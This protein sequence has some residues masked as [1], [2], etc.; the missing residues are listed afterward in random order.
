[1]RLRVRR[2]PGRVPGRVDPWR[3][4]GPF[5]ALA[6][7]A[8]STA[9]FSLVA[10]KS[11]TIADYLRRSS[12]AGRELRVGVLA[13]QPLLSTPVKDP[14]T[15]DPDA[16]KQFTGFDAS[17][18]TFLARS[19]GVSAEFVPLESTERLD[20]LTSGRV[21]V[22]LGGLVITAERQR[23]V[24]FAGP[25]LIGETV[26]A[27]RTGWPPGSE[28]GRL[29]VVPGSAAAADAARSGHPLLLAPDLR[30]C[31]A[32]VSADR[33]DAVVGD[34]ILLRG[35]VWAAGRGW[36]VVPFPGMATIAYGIG[37]AR[38]DPALKALV[39]SFLVASLRKKKS[40]AWEKA[41]DATLRKAGFAG[42]QPYAPGRLLRDGSDG[43]DGTGGIVGLPA[44][45][46]PV[47]AGRSR[48]G[49][50]LAHRRRRR[51]SGRT[52]TRRPARVGGT[53]AGEPGPGGAAPGVWSLLVGVP[54]AV[55]ALYLWIQSGGDRQFTLM[56]AQS[57]NPINFLA[58]VSL[59]V[60]WV[61]PALPA[62]VFIIGAVVLGAAVDGADRRRLRDRYAVAR[63]TDRAPGWAVWGSIL[64]A[65]AS[66]PLVFVPA[67]ALA[68]RVVGRRG[69]AG[70]VG[71]RRPGRGWVA[72]GLL[73]YA[74]VVGA[75]VGA[76]LA[77]G[78]QALALI[79]GWPAVLLLTR[80]TGPL[81]P[82][83][84]AAFVRAAALLAVLLTLGVLYA[85]VSTPILPSTAIQVAVPTAA[86]PTPAPSGSPAPNDPDT[87]PPTRQLRGY[88][89]STDDE[90]TTVLSDRGGVEIVA[91]D[92]IR[93]RVSCPSL[94]DLPGDSAELFGLPLRESLL[95]ALARRQRPTTVQDPRCLLRPDG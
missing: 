53:P 93:S 41:M 32:A 46:S 29:C 75:A 91:N 74:A 61:F 82:G 28:P 44:A 47:V 77:E 36:K 11:P 9:A 24:E 16:Q 26:M 62:L 39:D 45:V 90:A 86:P 6:L 69:A 21:D 81:R 83:Q 25:Y 57:I 80:A 40:G 51:T 84:V 54:V 68:L 14:G 12:I 2:L 50:T 94:V 33:A 34:E 71:G 5:L 73:L 85:V 37:V 15:T 87:D 23:V 20:A 59:S 79:A 92:V 38:D 76:A 43:Q 60:V 58:A 10:S 30:R 49:R 4:T 67:W 70:R 3:G 17:L 89:V 78:E 1:M 55:S 42:S 13:D 18:A 48:R 66:T 31:L 19:I 35:L 65:A 52:V 63:W 22:L 27:T 56:L 72:V 95:K 7:V 88:V 8:V 64:A